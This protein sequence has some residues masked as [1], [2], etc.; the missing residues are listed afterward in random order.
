MTI[1]NCTSHCLYQK[2]GICC[3]DNVNTNTISSNKDCVF[4]V[5]PFTTQAA[6]NGGLLDK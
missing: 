4:F 6:P 3:R 1:I 5:N 2:D